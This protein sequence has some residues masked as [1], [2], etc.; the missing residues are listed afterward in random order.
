MNFVLVSLSRKC[1]VVKFYGLMMNVVVI[2]NRFYVIMIF[3]IYMC[4]LIFCMI[5]LFGILNRK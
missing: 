2:E 3:V 5:R 1:V 4:V